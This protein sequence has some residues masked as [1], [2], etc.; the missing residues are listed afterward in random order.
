MFSFLL[1]LCFTFI[2]IF[3]SNFT[4]IFRNRYIF[5]SKPFCFLSLTTYCTLIKVF[6]DKILYPFYRQKDQEVAIMLKMEYILVVIVHHS[7]QLQFHYYRFLFQLYFYDWH[8]YQSQCFLI[9]LHISGYLFSI[10]SVLL[11]AIN[12]ICF[13]FCKSFIISFNFDDLILSLEW[14]K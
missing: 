9:L 10:F 4:F 8:Q 7:N 12:Q 3:I 6:A 1:L 14:F 2:F 5:S 13:T 11:L